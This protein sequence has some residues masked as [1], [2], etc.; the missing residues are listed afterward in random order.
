MNKRPDANSQKSVIQLFCSHVVRA[1]TKSG[2]RAHT[3]THTH[4]DCEELL[5]VSFIFSSKYIR[6]FILLRYLLD[7][8]VFR[9]ASLFSQLASGIH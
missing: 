7:S 6:A 1:V 3:H 4:T 5:S 8:N 9:L 2:A